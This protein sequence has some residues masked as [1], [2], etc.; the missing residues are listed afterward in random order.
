[1]SKYAE[2]LVNTKEQNDAALAPARADE[3]KAALGLAISKKELVV[4]GFENN[5]AALKRAYPLNVSAILEAT[6]ELEWVG[7][8]IVQLK[9]VAAELFA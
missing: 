8:E 7:R 3:Q 1:M 6:N 5:L 4:K 9:N 2:S